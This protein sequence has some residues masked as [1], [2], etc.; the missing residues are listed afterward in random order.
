MLFSK[1]N[2]FYSIGYRKF[3]RLVIQVIAANKNVL[4]VAVQFG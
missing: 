2:M 3:K 1:T 4:Q